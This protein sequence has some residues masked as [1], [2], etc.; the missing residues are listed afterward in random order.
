MKNKTI[1]PTFCIE[2]IP[3]LVLT[4]TFI[5]V[6]LHCAFVTSCCAAVKSGLFLESFRSFE[7]VGSF[8]YN[9][10]TKVLGPDCCICFSLS[11]HQENM[12]RGMGRTSHLM[13]NIEFQLKNNILNLHRRRAYRETVNFAPLFTIVK[14]RQRV[15]G[16][17]KGRQGMVTKKSL[18][19]TKVLKL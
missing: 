1:F 4:V 18:N 3:L 7:N 8:L 16:K 5:L 6:E 13:P 12:K 9:L 11:G 19:V 2:I 17:V 14:L 10:M 15:K